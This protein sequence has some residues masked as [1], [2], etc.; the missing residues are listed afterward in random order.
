MFRPRHLVPSLL[1]PAL[2][3]VALVGAPTASPVEPYGRPGVQVFRAGSWWNTPLPANT[4]KHRNAAAILTYLRTAE[5]AKGGCLRLAG[6]AR[7]P[8]G[9][10]VYWAGRGDR[11]Y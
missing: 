11:A 4:P 6:T 3:A 1:V 7:N 2:A 9:Q 8:W 5:D 10:P